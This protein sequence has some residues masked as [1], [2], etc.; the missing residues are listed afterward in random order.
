MPKGGGALAASGPSRHFVAAQQVGR[1][2]GKADISDKNK[3]AFRRIFPLPMARRQRLDGLFPS[4]SLVIVDAFKVV[5]GG[6]IRSA[7]G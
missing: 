3:H 4:P 2:P 6:R 5:G 1:F 7:C